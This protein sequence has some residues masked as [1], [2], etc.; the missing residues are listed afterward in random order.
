M[1]ESLE[2]KMITRE[3]RLKTIS[4]YNGTLESL[5]EDT[6]GD[7][8][9]QR[10]RTL[11]QINQD[12]VVAAIR[13]LASIS[14]AVVIVHGVVGCAASGLAFL[15]DDNSEI[16]L[17]EKNSIRQKENRI[18]STNLCERD[19]ILGGEEKLRQAI[20]RAYEETNPKVIF[21]V[22][23]PVVAINNDDVNSM[24]YDFEDIDA[25]IIPINTDGF[26]TKT[27]I[28][29]YDLVLHSLLKYVVKGRKDGENQE[30]FLNVV[31]VSENKENRDAISEIL[32]R[33]EIS[34]Q[35][36]PNGQDVD[37]IER[38]S[39]AKATIVLNRD[40]GEY[41][42]K[43]LEDLYGVPYVVTK[44][45]IGIRGTRHFIRQIAKLYNIEERA[46]AY[47][48]NQEEQI[49]RAYAGNPLHDKKVFVEAS[50]YE[51]PRFN[52]FIQEL[53]GELS[54]ICVPYVDENDREAFKHLE[55]VAKNIPAI[56]AVGQLFEKANVLSKKGA[57]YYISTL[58]GTSFVAE[59]GTLPINLKSCAYLGYK[60]IVRILQSIERGNL[61]K[62]RYIP[63]NSGIAYKESWL[64]KSSNWYVKK[65]VS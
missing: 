30:D 25:K 12:E 31:S 24:L 19:T 47:I 56:V 38:A 51:I 64:K 22:G 2:R 9:K 1:S 58:G 63:E 14:Q 41:F 13:V 20:N 42:A 48:S 26:K 37:S 49:G 50:P 17:N 65:E 55:A 52:T 27:Y 21:I 6:E 34:Y 16:N 10:I 7:Q 33:L 57:D 8:L 54:G 46:E 28:T 35:F 4:H 11:T 60:G 15:N 40:E 18:Y 32:D 39:Y 45:P 23:T 5:L 44:P 53:G 61:Q 62:K 3:K 36:L 43:K 59:R 29:G